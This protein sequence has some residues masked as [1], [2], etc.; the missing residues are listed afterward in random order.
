MIEKS[1]GTPLTNRGVVNTSLEANIAENKGETN[2]LNQFIL[3]DWFQF[4]LF[5]QNDDD[6]DNVNDTFFYFRGLKRFVITLFKDLF[7]VQ[8]NEVV[9]DNRG[10]NGYSTRYSYNSI[11]MYT[12][13]DRLDMGINIK[14]S[15]QACRE[16]EQLNNDWFYLIEKL[17]NYIVKY[18]RIDIAIDDFTNKYYSIPKLKRYIKQGRVVTKFRSS[19]HIEKIDLNTAEFGGNTV[20][21]GSKASN[22]Q[23]TFYDKKLERIASNNEFFKDVK[24]W[25]RCEIR[26]RH[27]M[28]GQIV[29]LISQTKE[30]NIYVKQ[31]LLNY[32]RF[33]DFSS[34][35]NKA[36][37]VT[38]KFWSDF[39]EDL[40]SLKLST[41]LPENTIV[42]K[43]N[44]LK[45]DTAKSQLMVL[46]SEMDNFE[47]DSYSFKFIIDVLLNGFKNITNKDLQ[48]INSYRSSNNLSI[49]DYEQISD[50]I[51]DIKEVVVK[52]KEVI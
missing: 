37:W 51:K 14:L 2:D 32:I 50:Y 15:G 11:E 22:V 5:Y 35:T 24:Y 7:N 38:T 41:Y 16:F 49:L 4:T 31:V 28:A 40:E 12:C 9:I 48:I 45:N 8:E 52:K 44:W 1:C 20:Q 26:F 36:R 43:K 18:N 27:E 42:R 6:L 30:L 33:V 21:F 47:L 25:V 19:L 23:V 17:K 46:I 10:I 29:T 39:V 3:I 13:E 34:D